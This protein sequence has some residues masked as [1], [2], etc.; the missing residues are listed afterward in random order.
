MRVTVTPITVGAFGTVPKGLKKNRLEELEI[1]GWIKTIHT[2]ALL[3]SPTILS[4]G[5]LKR[6]AVIQTPVKNGMKNL[7]GAKI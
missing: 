5:E 4:P 2:T 3:R 6:F 7:Q 1:L